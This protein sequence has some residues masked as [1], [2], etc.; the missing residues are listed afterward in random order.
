M[1]KKD[2]RLIRFFFALRSEEKPNL[3]RQV[4]GE[5]GYRRGR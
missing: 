2:N 4:E 1:T 5:V 3:E